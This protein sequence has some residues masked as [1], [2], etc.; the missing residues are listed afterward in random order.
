MTALRELLATFT[1]SVDPEGNLEKGNRQ[2][3]A[4]ADKMRGLAQATRLLGA[5]AGGGSAVRGLL[6]AGG[7]GAAGGPLAMLGGSGSAIQLAKITDLWGQAFPAAAGKA[8][9]VGGR[10]RGML[11]GWRESLNTPRGGLISSLF[12]MKN[13]LAAT[14]A[15]FAFMQ[16]KALVDHIGGIGEEASRLGVTNAEFQ[17]LDVLAKQNATSVG[18]LGTAF[19]T[20][21]NNAVTPTDEATEAFAKLGVSV[22]D[23]NGA[24]KTRQD[25]FFETAGALAD[26][27]DGTV[28]A[29]MAQKLYGRGALELAPLLA[30]GRAGLEAQRKELEKLPVL[31]DSLIKKADAFGDSWEVM[32]VQLMA[33]AGPVLEGLVIPAL[34][35]LAD[36]IGLLSDG[37][38]ALTKNLN[39]GRIAFVALLFPAS[40]ML[41][42]LSGLVTLGGGWVKALGGMSGG[43]KK[44]VVQFAP[45]IGAFLILEDVLGFFAGKDSLIGRGLEKAFPG[46]Q[47]VA[48]ELTEAFKDL[49]NWI[50]GNGQGEK[51]K[52]LYKEIVEGIELLVHDLLV[53]V[54]VRTGAKGLDG[55]QSFKEG[56]SGLSAPAKLLGGVDAKD[57]FFAKLNEIQASRTAGGG[58]P[59][60]V[61]QSTKTVTVNMLPNSSPD[62]VANKVQSVLAPDRNATAARVP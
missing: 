30:N 3:D 8:L 14:G 52:A 27:E 43:V 49:W 48:V 22:K 6:G 35:L 15:G 23:G 47:K 16:V 19:K 55:L 45:L 20:L 21:A 25:L 24:F 61:D 56:K 42:T 4:L 44:L 5:G 11:D 31:S 59:A 33:A 12:T 36:T 60:V 28:R 13:A 32:K 58:A 38:G 46:I 39:F 26:I 51:A 40:R 1:V 2:V 54:G 62:Q 57:P 9:G 17:R 7:G 34:Q 50:T 29:Q 37:I 53:S 41:A 10:I 18:A